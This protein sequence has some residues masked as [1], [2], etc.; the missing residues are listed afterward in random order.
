M[1][2]IGLFVIY[3]VLFSGISHADTLTIGVGR[4]FYDGSD[5]RAFSARINRHMGKPDLY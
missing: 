3:I 4:D 1:Y 5:S 2:R